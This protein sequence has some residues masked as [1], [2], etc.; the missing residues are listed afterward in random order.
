MWSEI[1]GKPFLMTNKVK[2]LFHLR[3]LV[4][5]PTGVGRKCSWLS[6]PAKEAVL[7]SSYLVGFISYGKLSNWGRQVTLKLKKG[8]FL[9]KVSLIDK[10]LG[11]T[12]RGN[13]VNEYVNGWKEIVH[14]SARNK[15]K[16]RR[17]DKFTDFCVIYWRSSLF[18]STE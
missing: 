6:A 13:I 5:N 3:N 18:Y 17:S 7:N 15:N 16:T 12:Y 8:S 11:K 2:D 4:K 1:S 14:K 9:W 10:V